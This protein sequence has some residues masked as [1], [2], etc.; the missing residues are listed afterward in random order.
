MS[1]N[2]FNAPHPF[3]DA[4]VVVD[5]LTRICS[6]TVKCLF[7]LNISCIHTG[8]YGVPTSKNPEDS[9]FPARRPCSGV[10]LYLSVMTGITDNISHSTENVPQHYQECTESFELYNIYYILHIYII[11]NLIFQERVKG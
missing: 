1:S 11:Y 3:R 2:R 5:C 6:A 9:N 7:I 8:F 10:L 4:G